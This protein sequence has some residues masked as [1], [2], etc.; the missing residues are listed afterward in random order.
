MEEEY[1]WGLIM[2][3]AAPIALMEA[4]VFY[5]NI[6]DIWRWI[7]LASGL[8]ITGLLAY[9]KDKKRNN[10][11]TAVGIVFLAALIMRFLKNFGLF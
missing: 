2:K 7:L 1:H 8:L 3:I 5:V 10:V 9:F 11:L 4:V 6:A